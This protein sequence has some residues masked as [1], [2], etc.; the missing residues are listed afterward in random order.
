MA[1]EVLSNMG[2]R[3]VALSPQIREIV[4][5]IYSADA[6]LTQAK[7]AA[8]ER[9]LAYKATLDA[10]RAFVEE[11]T[12]WAERIFAEGG[13]DRQRLRAQMV[14]TMAQFYHSGS[15][16]L[17]KECE[18]EIRKISKGIVCDACGSFDDSCHVRTTPATG[19]V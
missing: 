17:F 15:L 8:E 16:R 11:E 3:E 14:K 1:H 7:V 5:K 9:Y 19:R 12:A 4:A 6:A 13:G 10:E 18:I 2:G